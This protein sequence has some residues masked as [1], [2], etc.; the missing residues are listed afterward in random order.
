MSLLL[1]KSIGAEE[2]QLAIY[3]ELFQNINAYLATEQTTGQV[4]DGALASLNGRVLV[5]VTLELF[6]PANMHYGHRPSMIE[7]PVES[8]PSFA[9]AC[10]SATAEGSSSQNDEVDIFNLRCAVE[11]IVKSGP[12]GPDDA[13]G[14]GEDIVD[15]RIKRTAEAIHS[16]IG[17]SE[18]PGGKFLPADLPPTVN[19]GDIF[20]RD[21]NSDNERYYWQGV[22]M[23]Y[24]FKKFA[25]FDQ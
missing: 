18:S 14:D 21:G 20:A 1:D 23:E 6:D 13:V 25:A 10:Y 5:P 8:Y 24:I 2:L 9:V 15:R 3:T 22:R 4:R 11:C 16:V 12:F 7:A 17:D 19:W